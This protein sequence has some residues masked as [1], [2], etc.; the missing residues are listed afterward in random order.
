MADQSY[1]IDLFLH[2]DAH[3]SEITNE[4]GLLTYLLLF[5]IIFCETGLVITAFLPGDSLIFATGALAASGSFNLL[6][7]L[8]V[9]CLA[10]IAG[11]TVNYHIGHFLGN[12]VTNRENMRFIKKKQLDRTH[13]FF[14]KYG[15]KTIIIARFIPVIRTFAPFVAGIGTMPYSTFISYN[16]IGGVLWVTSFLFGGYFFGNLLVVKDNFSFLVLGVVLVSLLSG[17]IA[18]I[19]SKRDPKGM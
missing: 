5:A 16:I 10:A 4:Y 3:L 6:T 19:Q 18:Y 12:R 14:E 11:D 15:V 2:L 1:F 8:I 13:L 17:I 9:L 7:L